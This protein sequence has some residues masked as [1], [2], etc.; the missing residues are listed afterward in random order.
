MY[1]SSNFKQR[2]LIARILDAFFFEPG[3]IK[4]C[5]KKAHKLF[6]KY[7]LGVKYD[8][9]LTYLDKDK[10]DLTGVSIP[11]RLYTALRHMAAIAAA[12][13]RSEPQ[14]QEHKVFRAEDVDK[15]RPLTREEIDEAEARFR[16]TAPAAKEPPEQ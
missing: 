4:R 7:I 6:N 5:H 14:Q 11:Y 9:Y 12:L 8:T 2:I 15:I 1:N 13:E 10:Y 3:N 16:E